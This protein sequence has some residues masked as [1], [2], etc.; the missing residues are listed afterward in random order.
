MSGCPCTV[1]AG[2]RPTVPK[3][4]PA[5]CKED[6][7]HTG[8]GCPNEAAR[9]EP[10]TVCRVALIIFSFTRLKERQPGKASGQDRVALAWFGDSSLNKCEMCVYSLN[11][12]KGT[13]THIRTSTHAHTHAHTHTYTYI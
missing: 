4:F 11:R 12:F 1:D 5:S 10:A 2:T 8:Q 3:S 9:K 6:G 7:R 13:H